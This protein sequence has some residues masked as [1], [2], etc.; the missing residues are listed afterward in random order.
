MR[1]YRYTDQFPYQ[2]FSNLKGKDKF[3]Y[4]K[5][6]NTQASILSSFGSMFAA[7]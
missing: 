1:N 7:L 6:F 2:I 3:T 4:Y 5:L